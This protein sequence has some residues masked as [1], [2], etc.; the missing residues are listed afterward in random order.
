MTMVSPSVMTA[1]G[2]ENGIHELRRG[3]RCDGFMG[4]IHMNN[5]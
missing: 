4:L 2:N 5:D 1:V 3:F